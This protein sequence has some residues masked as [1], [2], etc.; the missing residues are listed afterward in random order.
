MLEDLQRIEKQIDAEKL[1]NKKVLLI[2]SNGFLGSWFSDFF[3]YAGVEYLKYDIDDGFDICESL[4]DLNRYDFVINCAGIA[5]PEKYMKKPIET[6]DISYL[7][8]KSVLNYCHQHNVESVLLFSSSE[9]YGTP[10]ARAI[11]TSEDYI[12]T[13][14]TMG[15][16]SCYDIGKQVL[17]TLFYIYYNKYKVRA[18]V[19]RP[20]NIYGP[21]MGTK[22]NRVLS[23]WMN[24]FID[25]IPIKIYGD[26]KQTRTF[27]YASDAITMM[28]GVLLDGKNGE[29]YN[30]GNSTPE[31]TMVELGNKF[32]EVLGK[33]SRLELIKYPDDYPSDEPSRR[34][35]NIDK[36]VKTTNIQPQISLDVGLKKM[37]KY[38]IG[39]R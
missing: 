2:G 17:E 31:L 38:F 1:R 28:L 37:Y 39:E 11:P 20:F 27:C 4:H 19:V 15:N 30:V 25:D 21:Y 36:V 29:I 5:S 3:D 12:G 6:M 33:K 26:G 14:P 18:K 8:T 16:R 24:N 10:D 34:C 9:V 7:G 22:D 13:I 35:P 23:N 32:Y